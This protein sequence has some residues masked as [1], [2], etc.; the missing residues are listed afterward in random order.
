MK[1]F[2]TAVIVLLASCASSDA[3]RITYTQ[4]GNDMVATLSDGTNISA[5]CV[6]TT[7]REV[8]RI[9]NDVDNCELAIEHR[10]LILERQRAIT[11][12]EGQP[13]ASP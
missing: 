9:G 3:D 10:Q 4:V 8:T 11:E 1:I 5:P 7:A 2:H 12:R 6:F 13:A